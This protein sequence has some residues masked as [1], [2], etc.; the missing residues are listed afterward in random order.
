MAE[1]SD[2]P[3]SARDPDAAL[4]QL[5]AALRDGSVGRRNGPGGR[6][7]G[8][9]AI[10]AWAASGAMWLTGHPEGPPLSPAAAVIPA[11]EAAADAL[12][13]LAADRGG[14]VRGAALDVGELLTGRAAL[15][16]LHR[17]GRVSA[18]GSCRLL[19]TADGWAAVN[20]ARPS[21]VQ[22]VAALVERV[23]D[24]DAVAVLARGLARL[25]GA[26]L[27]ERATLLG[28]PAAVLPTEPSPGPAPFV[29]QRVGP[30]RSGDAAP[31]RP[32]VVDLSAMW[33]GP[34]CARLLG[35][36]GLRVVK[37]ESTRR[38]DGARRGHQGFFDWLHGGH[39]SVALDLSSSSG[40]A[41]L[42][43]LLAR[44]DVVIES[45]RPRALAQLGID[46]EA[47]VAGR[48]GTTW[49]S[50]TGYGR[51]GTAGQRVAFG[52]D[53]AVAAG[54]VAY[55]HEDRPVFC[56]DAIADPITGLYAALA[57]LASLAAGGGHLVEVAMAAAVATT[58]AWPAE[59]RIGRRDGRDTR[60]IDTPAAA[61]PTA[62]RRD[63]R[64][65][66]G[67][68]TPAAAEPTAER[69]DDSDTWIVDTAAGERPVVRPRPPRLA[70]AAPRA[71]ALGADTAAV[72]AELG[73]SP[74]SV[75]DSAHAGR[76]RPSEPC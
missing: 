60:G 31:A 15:R 72:L 36:A 18:N 30:T 39:E 48:P 1:G 38:L 16:G 68:D 20:L 66:R 5:A 22:A 19:P 67:I 25:S 71:R 62:E 46:A 59:P 11:L 35:Q 50:I 26:E 37:V 12:G 17:Q 7:G 4:S 54:L 58:L 56:A 76:A 55:D 28:L 2:Q 65:A 29:A 63:G 10:A 8:D 41:A 70:P 3:G 21:D 75:G 23:V 69:R 13:R 44:A 6:S 57:A 45:S 51:T 53:A 73:L 52:D 34:L 43:Q 47:V 42:R 24:G 9:E 64:G 27:I 61:E 32:L 74:G 14:G 49:I 40:L 33:A